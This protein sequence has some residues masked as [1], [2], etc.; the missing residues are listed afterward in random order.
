MAE[1]PFP[2]R[3][4]IDAATPDYATRFAGEV[5]SY[6][7]ELQTE[8]TLDLLQPYPGATILDVGGGHGQLAI[9]LARQGFRV[10]V[11]GSD[12]SC[13]R[14][15]DTLMAP[16][17]FQ[18][19]TCDMLHLP[20]PDRSFDVVLSFRLLTH[21]ARWPEFIAELSRVAAKAVIIDYP[22]RRSVNILSSLLF[23]WKKSLEGNTRPY[24]LFS[25]R[26]VAAEFARHGLGAPLFHHEFFLPMVL[27]RKLSS[28]KASRAMERFCRIG[29]LTGLLGSPAIVRVQRQGAP[30]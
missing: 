5:G 10:T 12:D 30:L 24:T 27:H 3:A 23:G 19:R 4:D 1:P 15:L 22:D 11:T 13:G 8:M 20:Y 6:F 2:E 25:R 21:V 17:S 28:A 16:G 18:Y 29:G 7:L 26:Q 14:Y 9:P